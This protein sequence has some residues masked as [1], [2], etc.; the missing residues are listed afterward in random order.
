MNLKNCASPIFSHTSRSYGQALILP[1][2]N[3]GRLFAYDKSYD[4]VTTK[5]ERPLQPLDR[6]KYNPTTSDDPIIQQVRLYFG[7][8]H[9]YWINLTSFLARRQECC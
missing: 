1:R 6:M 3:Y 9:V 4:R 7:K 5:T 2:E 8:L